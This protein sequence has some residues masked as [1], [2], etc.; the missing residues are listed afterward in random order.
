MIS[1]AG[2]NAVGAGAMV[3]AR[4]HG[5]RRAGTPYIGAH[6]PSHTRRQRAAGAVVNIDGARRPPD[7]RHAAVSRTT[8]PLGGRHQRS[9]VPLA[10]PNRHVPKG[11]G[12][13]KRKD[14]QA[15]L[16]RGALGWDG[17]HPDQSVGRD[18][19]RVEAAVR[20]GGVVGRAVG[21][22]LRPR[23]LGARTVGPSEHPGE[24][25]ERFDRRVEQPIG[26]DQCN[27]AAGVRSIGAG[28]S[29]DARLNEWHAR[30]V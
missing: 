7:G 16:S 18:A 2:A 1:G 5:S 10:L 12:A 13:G 9:N 4:E 26:L 19:V 11:V 14:G 21:R 24:Q 30:L 15:R 17:G 22:P 27:G 8:P 25:A 28:R 23:G 29:E 20:P 6:S 3:V